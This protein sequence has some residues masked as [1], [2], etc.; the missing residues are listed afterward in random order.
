M[1]D[2]FPVTPAAQNTP[3]QLFAQTQTHLRPTCDSYKT[4]SYQIDRLRR[5]IIP[6]NDDSPT[7][8]P[9]IPSSYYCMLSWVLLIAYVLVFLPSR[10]AY[11]ITQY[12]GFQ[13]DKEI[14][15]PTVTSTS[16]GNEY[17]L[18]CVYLCSSLLLRV[19]Q[20][21]RRGGGT[22]RPPPDKTRR[23]KETE[24]RGVQHSYSKKSK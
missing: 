19:V 24:D 15:A 20:Q 3:Y 23:V 18:S 5:S 22:C 9:P 16:S 4:H 2:Y 10:A 14:A 17:G 6:K 1:V 8:I 12:S 11:I 13:A 21:R 7:Q